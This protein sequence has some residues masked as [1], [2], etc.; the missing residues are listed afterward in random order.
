MSPSPGV[1]SPAVRVQDST[2]GV[3]S[4]IQP[5]LCRGPV[6]S[7][8]PPTTR[9]RPSERNECPAQNKES[10]GLLAVAA[11]V[12]AAAP[13]GVQS[14]ESLPVGS[15]KNRTLPVCSTAPWTGRSKAPA[16]MLNGP[17]HSPF[18]A[19]EKK[20]HHRRSRSRSW[21]ISS[22][23]ATRTKPC[24]AFSFRRFSISAATFSLG[25]LEPSSF[26][27]I[28]FFFLLMRRRMSLREPRLSVLHVLMRQ[29]LWWPHEILGS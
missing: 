11:T 27:L 5:W 21:S 9:S 13:F 28:F 16:G 4:K 12:P 18:D 7:P 10:P 6:P 1:P 17:V 15:P 25:F 19:L 8:P 2:P 26:S 3:G 22:K 14:Q 20:Y 24:K 23:S 29:D